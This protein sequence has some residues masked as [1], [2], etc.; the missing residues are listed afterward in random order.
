MNSLL[1]HGHL[2]VD[3]NR[4]FLDGAL[5]IED[6][7]IREVYPQSGRIR[8]CP[9]DTKI[10]DLGGSLVMPGFFD[11]HTHGVNGISFDS[12]DL[13]QMEQASLE[14]AKDGS[15]SY[16]CTLSYDLSIENIHEQLR[17]LED[18]HSTTARFEGIHLEGP[19]LS[20]K[21]LGM[22]DPEH[23]LNPD[24][25]MMKEFLKNSSRIRQVTIAYELEGA[26]EIGRLLHENG[27]KVM[28]G[29]SDAL[30]EDLDENVDGFTHLFNAMRGLHHRDITLVNCAFM[31]R[32]NYELIADGN[33]VDRNVL[34]L[35]LQ[36]TDRDRLMLV[37]DSSIARNLP[38]GEYDFISKH[39]V[40]KG[41][42]FISVDGHYAGS[43]VSINDEMKVLHELGA[44]YTDLLC[45]SGLNA[46]TFYG[47]DQ[48]YGSLVKGKHSDLVIM[49]DDLNIRNV[50]TRGKFIDD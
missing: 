28:C 18:Y 41:T 16:L 22:G 40:K 19:F 32:W 27:I 50:M 23:F 45:Y 33:H 39:C 10:I 2:I 7:R 48:Q 42:K 4:E 37:T 5:F 30:L 13:E 46:F 24:L 8:E 35:L 12:A 1:I 17:R 21:H 14:F 11:T 3:G 20:R 43:V 26:K 38:D 47:L 36:Q 31:N 34:K 29:H 15:T 44:K 9:E 25:E 49:D 6:E